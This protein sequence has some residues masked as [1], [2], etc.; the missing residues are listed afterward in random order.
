MASP[1]HDEA[2]IVIAASAPSIYD[3]VAD[4]PR[5]GEWSPECRRCEWI[6]G[7]TGAVIGAWFRGHNRVGPVR[8]SM[9][10]R[11][12][13]ADRGREFTFVTMEGKREGT[14]WTYRFEPS[15]TTTRVTESYRVMYEPLYTRIL[16]LFAPRRRL[17]RRGM[18]RTLERIKV[19]AEASAGTESVG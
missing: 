7:S 15:S 19:A 18:Q 5:M 8:W 11:V 2:E 3:L 12:L 6:D 16:D 17:L 14:R 13:I 10:G 1:T 9:R 4:M